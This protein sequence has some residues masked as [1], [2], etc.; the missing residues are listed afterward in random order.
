MSQLNN[1][2]LEKVKTKLESDSSPLVKQYLE[3][4]IKIQKN[5]NPDVKCAGQTSG[6]KCQNPAKYLIN[7]NLSGTQTK[8]CKTH[9]FALGTMAAYKLMQTTLSFFMSDEEASVDFIL[10]N[11]KKELFGAKSKKPKSL[12]SQKS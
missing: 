6:E 2:E 1:N 5:E 3:K 11:Q 12:K 7:L 9:L 10:Q 4:L 8:L